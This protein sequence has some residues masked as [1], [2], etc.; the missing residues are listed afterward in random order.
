[1][2]EKEG[3]SLTDSDVD[4]ICAVVEEVRYTHEETLALDSPHRVYWDE[5][6]KFNQLKDKRQI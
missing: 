2:H 6:K 3:V 5:Q 4:D 1:M